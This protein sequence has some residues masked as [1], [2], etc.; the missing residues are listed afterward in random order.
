[1]SWEAGSNRTLQSASKLKV[2]QVVSA[3]GPPVASAAHILNSAHNI[4]LRVIV[5][6]GNC[7]RMVALPRTQRFLADCVELSS[8]NRT[9]KYGIRGT[10]GYLRMCSSERASFVA[11]VALLEV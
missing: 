6:I 9:A 4:Y 7:N 11:L 2:C 3:N 1:M 10:E 8:G 5:P